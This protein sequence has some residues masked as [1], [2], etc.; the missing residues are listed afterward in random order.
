VTAPG[1]VVWEPFGGL[2]TASVAAVT[3]GRLAYAAELVPR[4]AD[5][6]EERLAAAW[7]AAAQ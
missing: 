2:C 7:Q 1:D 4:F 6:A 5:L 3:S